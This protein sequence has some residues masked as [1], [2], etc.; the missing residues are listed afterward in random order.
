MRTLAFVA[1][2]GSAVADIL[3]E[4]SVALGT[5]LSTRMVIRI[6]GAT[7]TKINQAVEF[8]LVTKAGSTGLVNLTKIVPFAGGLV[9]G[10]FDALMTRG[11]GAAAKM[12]ITKVEADEPP[13]GLEIFATA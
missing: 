5:K 2:T 1:L 9:G 4:L 6:S 8:R 11:I 12:V 7:L 10:G 3:Q 13:Q